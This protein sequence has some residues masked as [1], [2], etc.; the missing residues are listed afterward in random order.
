MIWTKRKEKSKTR[1]T[2]VRNRDAARVRGTK[3][4]HRKSPKSRCRQL[5]SDSE[6]SQFNRRPQHSRQLSG[7]SVGVKDCQSRWRNKLDSWLL[8]SYV[9]AFQGVSRCSARLYGFFISADGVEGVLFRLDSAVV[10]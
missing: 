2:G 8:L 4:Q 7:D 1:P 3:A 9:E 5:H 6:N 10:L